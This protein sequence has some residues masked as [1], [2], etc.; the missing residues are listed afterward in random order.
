[1]TQRN[2]HKPVIP[3]HHRVRQ[4]GVAPYKLAPGTYGDDGERKGADA[5]EAYDERR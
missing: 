5:D 2:R 1:M 3:V 4:H